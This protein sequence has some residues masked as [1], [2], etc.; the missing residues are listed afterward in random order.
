MLNWPL[1]WPAAMVTLPD[2]RVPPKAEAPR[3]PALGATTVYCRVV[4]VVDVPV[5]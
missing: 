1:V 4:S 5:R 3:S 2:G